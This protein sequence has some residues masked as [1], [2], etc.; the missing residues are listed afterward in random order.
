MVS[1][2]ANT[3]KLPVLKTTF[4]KENR[5]AI[6]S[7][8]IHLLLDQGPATVGRHCFLPAEVQGHVKVQDPFYSLSLSQLQ[9]S[10]VVQTLS[11]LLLLTISIKNL[12]CIK[13]VN[14]LILFFV[15]Y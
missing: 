9:E 1:I 6:Y 5:L 13:I 4:M 2:M 12:N 11:F 8:D 14:F 7:V 10:K 3:L 15:D